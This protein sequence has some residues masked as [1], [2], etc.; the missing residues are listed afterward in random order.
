MGSD[1]DS[2]MIRRASRIGDMHPRKTFTIHENQDGD[3]VVSIGIGKLPIGG[4]FGE[5]NAVVEF[6]SLTAG[7]G[8]SSNTHKA[9]LALMDAMKKDNEERPDADPEKVV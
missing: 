5:E 3:I 2:W 9:L 8:R 1:S 7:G 4:L 6:C